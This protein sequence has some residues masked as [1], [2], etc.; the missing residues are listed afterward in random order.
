MP[1]HTHRPPPTDVS[2]TARIPGGPDPF[3]PLPTGAAPADLGGDQLQQTLVSDRHAVRPP[4]STPVVFPGYEIL[5]ELG[6]GGMGV[7]YKARQRN[8]NRQ[9]ALKVILGGPLAS[10]E[11]KARFRVEAEAAARLQHPNIVQV[12]DVGE[13]AGFAYMALELIEGSTRRTWQDGARVDARTAARLVATLARAVHHAHEQGIVHRD[14][15]PANVLLS[16]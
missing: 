13:Y 7:V 11:D 3:A 10:P 8:L 1:E 4:V 6:R 5:E 16:R 15:K 14:I 12:Y 9:V 2:P